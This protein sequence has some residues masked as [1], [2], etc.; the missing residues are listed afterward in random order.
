MK[1]LVGAAVHTDTEF[2]KPSTPGA[3]TVEEMRF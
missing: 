2:D 1:T 3:H